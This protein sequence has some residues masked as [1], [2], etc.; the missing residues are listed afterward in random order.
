M[1]SFLHVL[2]RVLGIGGLALAAAGCSS[3][4]AILAGESTAARS[5]GD[6]FTLLF[7]MSVV[8]F[9]VT[10]G[11]L[12]Y[13]ILRFRRRQADE[14]PT[15]VHGNSA[16]EVAWT[17]APALIV[18]FIFVLTVRTMYAVGEAPPGSGG[19]NVN[20]TGHQWWW[21]F[22]YPDLGIVT[23][24]ELY[25]PAGTT[26]NLSL[27]S[28][29]VIHSF[30][31]PQLNGKTD[32]I[33]GRTNTAWIRADRP[34]TYV[35]QCAEFCGTQH[36]NMRMF[37][38][39]VSP[40]DFDVWVARMKTPAATPPEGDAAR[41][42]QVFEGAA[43]IGCHTVQG[44]KGVGKLGPNLTHIGSHKSLAAGTLD[45]TPDNLTRWLRDP[46]AVKPGT[47]MPKVDLA[48]ADRNA[49][50]AYLLSLK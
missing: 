1:R 6:L 41:G 21:E 38:V 39:A 8:I 15:Q 31:F 5:I 9:I 50:V 27:N 26:V 42:K 16:L 28:T 7:W 37:V 23:A 3:S 17:L 32:A 48:D 2:T 13:A 11:V 33:P 10:E 14:I 24:D 12:L 19:I 47:L 20:V 43:C 29:D 18:V 35:G 4:P 25:V 49:L 36:A 44:T 46:Q 30:W 40:S 45:L 22:Q 34:G